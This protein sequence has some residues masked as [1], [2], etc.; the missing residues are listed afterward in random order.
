MQGINPLTMKC[1]YETPCGWCTK[2]D[3]KCD[4]KIPDPP[5]INQYDYLTETSTNKICKTDSDHQWV[6]YGIGTGGTTYICKIC[7]KYKTEP[8][9]NQDNVTISAY[10][11]AKGE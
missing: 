8:I 10:F 1:A 7:G 9:W 11:N 6:C 3:K 5:V 4:M 2:W